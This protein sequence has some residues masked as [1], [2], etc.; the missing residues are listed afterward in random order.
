MPL[1][2]ASTAARQITPKVRAMAT[3][4][5]VAQEA[6]GTD[7]PLRPPATRRP[8]RSAGPRPGGRPPRRP[9]HREPDPAGA[10]SSAAGPPRRIDHF[11]G[12]VLHC[13]TGGASGRRR[14]CRCRP[15]SPPGLF[16][17]GG[18]RA[19]RR[20]RSRAQSGIA[21]RPPP[22]HAAG[23]TILRRPAQRP[24][25]AL[26][27]PAVDWMPR[28]PYPLLE[29]TRRPSRYVTDADNHLRTS[30]TCCASPTTSGCRS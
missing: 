25:I 28:L 3:I 29:A 15:A 20:R 6:I 17:A 7:P 14:P 9:E 1:G 30:P 24:R 13:L 27:R 18:R 12:E 16:Q 19:P 8:S 2:A 23:T 10:G 26:R 5:A 11:R 4:D 22:R 21:G